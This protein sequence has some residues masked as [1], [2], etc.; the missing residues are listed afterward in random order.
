V[1]IVCEDRP[2]LPGIVSTPDDEHDGP[3]N[4]LEGV[5]EFYVGEEVGFENGR[6]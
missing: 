1:A 4:L 6:L 3:G 5:L 2:G